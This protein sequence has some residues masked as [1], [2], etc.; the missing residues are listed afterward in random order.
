MKHRSIADSL[1]DIPFP[2]LPVNRGIHAQEPTVFFEDHKDEQMTI[3]LWLKNAKAHDVHIEA[4]EQSL[5]IWSDNKDSP[6]REAVEMPRCIKRDSLRLEYHEDRVMVT[7]T[8]QERTCLPYVV[9]IGGAY[10]HQRCPIEHPRSE[11]T[12]A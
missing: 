11:A 3:V 6:I 2:L 9:P 10:N 1:E 5:L 4:S 7:V 8:F 12:P